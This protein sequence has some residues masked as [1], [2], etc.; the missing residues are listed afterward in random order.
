MSLMNIGIPD[1][2]GIISYYG[3]DAQSMIHME[4][5]A[6]L[7]QAISKVRRTVH[8]LGVPLDPCRSEDEATAYNHLVE[9]IS[10]V[11]ICMEQMTEMYGIK[12]TEIQDMVAMK[13]ARQE[14]RMEKEAREK[15][16][17]ITGFSGIGGV[18]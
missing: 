4:E 14:K 11:L 17:G 8:R 1:Q 3:S 15:V 13:C 18:Q 16:L 5:C 7:I 6:E 2:D 10:D 12:N 9:E